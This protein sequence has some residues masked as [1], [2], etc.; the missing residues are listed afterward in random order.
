MA[1][2]S[3]LEDLI[4]EA[5]SIDGND[6]YYLPRKMISRDLILNEAVESRFTEAYTIEM[7]LENVDGFSGDGTLFSKFGLEIRDQATLVVSKKRWEQLV[8]TDN[9]SIGSPRPLEGDLLYFP[10]TKSFFEIKF[11][12]HQK[13]FYQL[14]K[15]PVYKL[16]VELFEYSNEN[17]DTGI[18]ELDVLQTRF[19]TEYIFELN[20]GN[21]ILPTVGERVKQVLIPA[22]VSSPAVEI[23]GKVLG[24]TQ[25]VGLT[26][27]R[28]TL[29]EIKTNSGKFAKFRASESSLDLLVG[30]QSGMSRSVV[31]VLDIDN[32]EENTTFSNDG[33][34][35]NRAFEIEAATVEDFSEA[36]PF[37]TPQL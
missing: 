2:A 24:F 37:G 15:L 21:G 13:P 18:A 9:N 30:L 27:F 25:P 16:Q 31:R 10:L 6:F 32:P 3:L 11:V 23:S 36:N 29:G 22:T 17:V 1:E 28:I 19:A 26:P 33:G 5:L 20:A 12:D 34:A 14:A 35:Q 7:Y 8:G 4:I